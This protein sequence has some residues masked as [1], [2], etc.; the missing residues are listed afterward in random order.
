MKLTRQQKIIK[1]S[2]DILTTN[3]VEADSLGFGA[4]CL[5][6]AC[7]PYRNPKLEQLINGCWVHQNGFYTLWMQGGLADIT[8]SYQNQH[9]PLLLILKGELPNKKASALVHF[10][11]EHDKASGTFP[12]PLLENQNFKHSI[13]NKRRSTQGFDK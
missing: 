6:A 13:H 1:V 3:T 7:L 5:I 12:V 11:C 2:E 9:Y 8:C 4:K 10:G